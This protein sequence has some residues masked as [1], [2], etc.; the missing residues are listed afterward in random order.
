MVL[1]STMWRNV[2]N[3]LRDEVILRVF[4]F[5]GDADVVWGNGLVCRHWHQLTKSPVLWRQRCLELWPLIFD[6]VETCPLSLYRNGIK[7]LT[8]SGLRDEETTYDDLVLLLCIRVTKDGDDGAPLK[9][10]DRVVRQQVALR[11]ATRVAGRESYLEFPIGTPELLLEGRKPDA[12][13]FM[14]CTF[15][16]KRDGKCVYFEDNSMVSSRDDLTLDLIAGRGTIFV[17]TL[18]TVG[19]RFQTLQLKLSGDL[20]DL[21]WE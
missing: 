5:G 13:I 15:V 11:D 2:A 17:L 6:E 20:D 18:R 12:G 1:M 10:H 7:P 4:W 3:D 19:P 9:G 8:G 16:R 21:P 14:Y